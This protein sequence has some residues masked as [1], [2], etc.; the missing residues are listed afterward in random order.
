MPP[1]TRLTG[2]TMPGRFGLRPGRGFK[3]FYCRPPVSGGRI[4]LLLTAF[5]GLRRY[6]ATPFS[7][8][9]GVSQMWLQPSTRRFRGLHRQ[10]VLE[11]LEN[12]VVPGFLAPLGFDVGFLPNSVASGD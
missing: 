4:M 2:P 11:R 5:G 12:R 8:R 7:F 3:S 9:E 6:S 1:S 10:L